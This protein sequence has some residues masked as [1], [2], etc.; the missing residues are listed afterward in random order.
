MPKSFTHCSAC[1]TAMIAPKS[2]VAQGA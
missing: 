2:E 1:N